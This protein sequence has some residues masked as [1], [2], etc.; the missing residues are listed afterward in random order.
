MRSRE[1]ESAPQVKLQPYEGDFILAS[2]LPSNDTQV[3]IR[4]P[5]PC[6]VPPLHVK[7]ISMACKVCEEIL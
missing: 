1:R 7:K 2:G 3:P 6:R 5:F 4:S